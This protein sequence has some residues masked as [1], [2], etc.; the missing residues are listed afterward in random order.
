MVSR[1]AVVQSIG[2]QPPSK[3]VQLLASSAASSLVL[4]QCVS[5]HFVC[6]TKRAAK[7]AHKPP[8]Q[9]QVSSKSKRLAL[10]SQKWHSALRHRQCAFA[11]VCVRVCVCVCL[12]LSDKC[13][14]TTKWNCQPLL[15]T[16]TQE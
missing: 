3:S 15:T 1:A 16:Q 11:Q 7:L 4:L 8:T 2:S 6:A 5:P 10:A 13:T 9:V 14:Q 12:T